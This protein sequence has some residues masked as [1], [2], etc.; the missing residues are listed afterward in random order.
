MHEE[1]DL[2]VEQTEAPLEATGVCKTFKRADGTEVHALDDVS[3]RVNAGEMVVLLGPSGC[4]KTTLLRCVAGLE[5]PDSGTMHLAGRLV[6]EKA[7]KVAIPAN[8]RDINMMF[9]TYAL[10]P[11]MT[12]EDNV[13][14]PLRIMGMAKGKAR[15]RA[16]EY[17]D[18]VG[19]GKLG[20][21]Y[22]SQ[23]SGGQA[24]RAALA[25]TLVSNP[26]LVLFDEPL[27]NVDA[28]VRHQLRAEI[29]RL[30]RE[31]KFAALYVTHDQAEAMALGD[32][33]A[34]M[35]EGKVEEFQAP[36][37]L[38]AH[39]QSRFAAAFLGSANTVEATVVKADP[40]T[41]DVRCE[42]LG[43]LSVPKPA[44]VE[45]AAG[46]Q[47]AIMWRPENDELVAQ[48]APAAAAGMLCVKGTIVGSIFAG[49]YTDYTVSIG[50]KVVHSWV[51]GMDSPHAFSAGDAVEVRVAKDI[52]QTLVTE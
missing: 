31:L 48:S 9:Q 30:H 39:P 36:D 46:Q 28:K 19:I 45:V 35:S 27:S 18:L 17:L 3:L 32:R 44:G 15:A 25:R 1:V 24:Q 12:L 50:D 43:D 26:A 42:T 10:W 20:K 6:Y 2:T 22:A 13:A 40:T 41:L 38:Y 16:V 14:Y 37:L 52:I 11:H 29:S 8:R 5:H 7:K 47:V 49:P 33:V 34:V 51:Y 23:V 4:G 21:Q